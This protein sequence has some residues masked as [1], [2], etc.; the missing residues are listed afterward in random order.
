MKVAAVIVAAGRGRRL[1][2]PVP[3]QYRQIGAHMVL[4]HTLEAALASPRIT[5]VLTAIT[6]DCRSLY[7]E[8]TDG[9][10]DPRLG[11]AVPGGA[12]RADT[13]RHALE[14]LAG[15][16]PDIVLVH[17]AARPFASTALWEA[18]IDAAAGDEGAIAA[19]PVVDAL[20][21]EGSGS[22]APVGC[23][24]EPR[25][26]AGL[27]RAQ[28]PQAFPYTAL[29]AAHRAEAVSDAPSALDDAEVFRRA[30]GTVRL[31]PGEPDNFKI[32]TPADLARAERL[33]TEKEPLMDVR[34]GHGFDVH[35]FGP[36][37]HV[38]LCG[39]AVPHSH[40]LVGHSDADVGLH[41]LADALYGALAE[42]DIGTHFPPS[43]P[44][45]K[46]AESHVFL[47][48]AGSLVAARGGRISNLD[49][50]LLCE[51][52]KIGPHAAAMRAK[53]GRI[54]GLDPG[55]IGL[56]ATTMERMGFVGREEGMGCIATATVILSVPA[57][58]VAA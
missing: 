58:P 37:D 9:L 53:I 7:N 3:K 41:A 16:A 32:T 10:E 30:G 57:G 5:R 23:C 55:R 44:Q 50:T 40:G 52:P 49:V 38:M 31:V 15:E 21:V 2:G 34:T 51:R 22:A 45:W 12:E 39:V 43:D 18:L 19:E 36:G 1:G 26:R 4:R 33:V 35:R 48:H 24:D 29:L 47:A 42:G 13:V 56:K 28:T 46:G 27:W 25:P 20:W 54:L 17:D 14:A 6:E 8:A 11:D